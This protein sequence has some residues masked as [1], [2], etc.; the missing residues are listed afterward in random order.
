[1]S[2]DARSSAAVVPALPV[3]STARASI[4]AFLA[5]LPNSHFVPK[6]NRVEALNS[7]LGLGLP[8]KSESS[9]SLRQEVEEFA[10]HYWQLTPADR[11]AA[12]L[13]LSTRSPD[14][15]TAH[16]LLG[17]QAGLELPST[18]FPDSSLEK[19]AAIARE[20]YVLPPRERA[21]RRN[22][23]LLKNASRQMELLTFAVS[24]QAHRPIYATLDPEL[25]AR[26]TPQFNFRLFAE[27]A[28]VSTLPEKAYAPTKP[29]AAPSPKPRPYMPRPKSLPPSEKTSTKG[30]RMI[31]FV[32]VFMIFM[33]FRVFSSLVGSPSSSNQNQ[34]NTPT[35]KPE[36][37]TNESDRKNILD[38][39]NER[40]WFTKQEIEAFKDYEKG[41][42][43][44]SPPNYTDWVNA[45]KP[46]PY[47]NYNKYPPKSSFPESR[48]SATDPM[49]PKR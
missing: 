44:G 1:M 6:Y 5:E 16:R 31:G 4:N 19:I 17:L 8:A 11:L 13:T 39:I 3:G 37:R 49:L 26:L 48:P 18:P 47:E 22:G 30:D 45:G 9:T 33:A 29:P 23:W 15:Q 46:R 36:F 40:N 10:K 14:D 20:L 43:T 27:A 34:Y 2:S 38:S 35:N 7:L 25:F 32:V 42:R 41:T 28:T 24:L 21:I 12:W